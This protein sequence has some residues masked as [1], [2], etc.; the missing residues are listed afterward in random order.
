MT[1]GSSCNA[2][3]AKLASFKTRIVETALDCTPPSGQLQSLAC[4]SADMLGNA[5]SVSQFLQ[6]CTSSETV[7]ALKR[8]VSLFG[9]GLILS[10]MG[11]FLESGFLSPAQAGLAREAQYQVL[12]ELRPDAVALVDAFAIPDYVLDSSLGRFDGNVYQ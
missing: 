9:L 12:R 7:L 2:T 6:A 5:G 4:S 3:Y 1:G 11:D 10:A 8:L